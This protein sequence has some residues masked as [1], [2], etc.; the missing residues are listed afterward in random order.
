MPAQA[1][2]FDAPV[3]ET[4][5]RELRGLVRGTDPIES[6]RAAVDV[7][8]G[9]TEKQEF[10]LGLLAVHGPMTD[11]E[12]EHLPEA[13]VEVAGVRKYAETTL[14]KRRHE[15]CEL[16]KVVKV[17]DYR[18]DKKGV[19]ELAE[20]LHL[21]R[22]KRPQPGPELTA[23]FPKPPWIQARVDNSPEPVENP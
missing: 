4:P 20:L 11:H 8:A 10:V 3:L 1:T 7:K 23:G 18:R 9:L 22:W 19:W 5:T 13:L 6:Q 17:P 21:E 2:L 15:L 14:S 12:L 16:G